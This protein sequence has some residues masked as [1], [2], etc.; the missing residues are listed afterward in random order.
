MAR[1]R[2]DQIRILGQ[3]F[4]SLGMSRRNFMKV[5]AAAAAGTATTAGM[6]RY[7]G[8]GA[9]AAPRRAIRR[10][11]ISPDRV[12][13]HFGLQDDPVS[14]DW[15][16]NL[17]CNAEETVAAGLLTFDADLNAI[18]DWA[19]TFTPNDDASVWTFNIRPDNVGWTNGTETR[20]VTAQDFVY[21]WE[22]Q[23]NPANAAAYAGFLFD[24][25]NAEKYNLGEEVLAPE[26]LGAVALDEWTLEVTME[27]PRAYFPQVVAYTAAVPSPQ[28]AVEEYGSDQWASANVPLWVN[29]PFMLDEWEHDVAAVMSP[30][31][32][33]WD[34]ESIAVDRVYSPIIP[35]E[36]SVLTY[37]RGEGNQKLD[38]VNIPASD[39]QRYQDDPELA[40]QLKQYVYPG[41]WMLVPS[42]GQEPF[43]NDEVGLQVRKA[44]SHAID[45][46][47]LG[48]LT[49]G[50]TAEAFGMVPTG[51][52]GYIDDPE[53]A[54]IQ[55]FDPAAA[56][57]MLVGTPF[58]GGQNWPEITMHMRG[59]EEIY[60][61]DLM[62]NDIV[63]QLQENLGMN[64]N[65]QVWPEASWRPELF[66]NEFQLVWIRWWY[67]YPDP[68][69]G[70]GDMFY[71]KKSSGK[72]QGWSNA[73]FDD[74]VD[75]GKGVAD[76]EGRLEIYTQAERIIQEDVGYIPVVY[77]VD[78]YAF[79]PWVKDIAVNRQ[80]FTVPDGNI[81]IRM[82][83]NLR[84]E[85]RPEE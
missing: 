14:W 35:A 44:L 70:Y 3:R 18:A 66:K 43:Q 49:N 1:R 55:A 67:D 77:R 60:N 47:R 36:S 68:N 85:G 37:E 21:S 81:Y 61:S 9:A 8:P 65:I 56:M 46:A 20:P 22:R 15:N 33:Y 38:W 62:A 50:Q 52:F 32:G 29:G 51:V 19:E 63:A 75:Q 6:E 73:E 74:L 53:I 25:K 7:V 16:L 2:D 82:L 13:Y 23:L 26:D 10:Q 78:N 80:G 76:P 17:Y 69:N 30:N 54:A 5:A 83:E 79:K 41:I 12:F 71:S 59:S 31:P 40:S 24:I 84:V 72:R 48:E 64:V 57:E 58:E 28:W 39:L 42:N 27:G 45:R 34:F 4:K 11:E